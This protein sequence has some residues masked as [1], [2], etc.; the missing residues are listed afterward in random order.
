MIEKKELTPD[1]NP[2]NLLPVPQ[3]QSASRETESGLPIPQIA[4]KFDTKILR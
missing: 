4:S 3:Q 1:T 2:E